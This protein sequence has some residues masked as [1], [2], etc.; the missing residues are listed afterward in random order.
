M[1][2]QKFR[3]GSNRVRFE[4]VGMEFA[5]Q[6]GKRESFNQ[7][8]LQMKGMN[9]DT[10]IIEQLEAAFGEEL[11]L[12]ESDLG[13]LEQLIRDGLQVLGRGLLQRVVNRQRNGYLGSS[14]QC[15]CGGSMRFVHYR[16]RNIH[17]LFGWIRLKRGYYHCPYCQTALAPYDK[18]SGLGREQLS[19]GLA[20]MCCLF[21]VADSFAESARKLEQTCGQRVSQTTI[22]RVVQQVGS[23]ALEQQNRGLEDFLSRRGPPEAAVHPQRLYVAADGTTVPEIDGWHEAKAGCIYWQSER[24]DRTK[25]YLACFDHS[26][27]FGWRLWLEACRCGLREAQEVVYL[28][29]GAGWIRSEH[30]RH[31]RRATFI[32]D[33]FHACEH[34]WDCGKVLFGEGT[35]ATTRWVAERLAL[36][37][38]GWTR[39]LL[40]ELGWQRKC[41]RG[42]KGQAIEKLSRYIKANEQQMRYDV[43]RAKG[44]DIGSGSAEGAC[45]HVIGKRLKQSGMIWSRLGSSTTLALRVI[46]LNDQWDILWSKKPLA[47]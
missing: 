8:N 27:K 34:V 42:G 21:A 44:Y 25:R 23:A 3:L 13:A 15:D 6:V 46:W 20:R 28:G 26:Q 19:P 12:V 33:W 2:I 45:K 38:D 24:F 5:L 47:A 29:D 9:M 16:S 22:E 31:F 43:F 10:K 30:N 40:D 1:S 14:I 18:A 39:K 32:I 41:H 37:W 35:D 4:F 36:L 7:N 11:R 17:T